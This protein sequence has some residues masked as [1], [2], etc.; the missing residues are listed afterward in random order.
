MALACESASIIERILS[1][2]LSILGVDALHFARFDPFFN[3]S[4]LKKIPL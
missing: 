2:A 4:S 1:I 3:S